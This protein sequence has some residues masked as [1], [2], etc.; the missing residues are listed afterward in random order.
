MFR[1]KKSP[2]CPNIA[3]NYALLLKNQRKDYD[4]A[5]HYFLH[6][7]EK[8]PDATTIRTNYA[9]FLEMIRKD[10][11]GAMAQYELVLGHSARS[12]SLADTR[13]NYAVL[14]AF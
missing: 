7:I 2:D 4:Q 13:A 12:P 14:Y 10:V 8:N 6:G 11:H 5:E 1:L 3:N 9:I